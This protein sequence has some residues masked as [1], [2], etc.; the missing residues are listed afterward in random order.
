MFRSS[1]PVSA[2]SFHNRHRE[3]ATLTSAVERLRQG[4]PAWIAVIG[5]RKIGKTSLVTEL[6][7]RVSDA[8]LLFVILDVFEVAPPSPEV[9][10][11]YAF[12]AVDRVLA[13]EVG[14][15]LERLARQPAAYRRALQACPNW[16]RLPAELRGDLA[17]LAETT[18]DQAFVRTC[19]E[20]PERLAAALGLRLVVAIDEFQELAALTTQRHGFDPFPLMRSVWQRHEHVGYIVSG[21][22]RSMLAELLTA[23]RAPFLQH[24]ATLD[25]GPFS[26]EDAVGL[27]VSQ[28]RAGPAHQ[29][30]AGFAGR[31]NPRRSPLLSAA[32][33]RGARWPSL[34]RPPNYR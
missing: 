14:E 17:E 26:H 33:G 28:S 12:R 5:S 34:A 21:S 6:A 29:P 23:K 2:D 30:R 15:S 22:S 13:V 20:L 3:L 27:L 9:F 16:S 8:T 10:R 24:F 19:L 18:C 25:L 32:P 7:R 4:T 11:L 1:L 31:R